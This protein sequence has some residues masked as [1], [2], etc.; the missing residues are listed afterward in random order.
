MQYTS[1]ENN[2]ASASKKNTQMAQVSGISATDKLAILGGTPVRTEPYPQWPVVDRRD[3]EA[4]TTVIQ[5]G[6]WGGA[7]YPGPQT[8]AF[9]KQFTAMQG[10]DFA[11]PMVNGT[12]TMEVALRAVNIGWGDEVIVPAYTFQ[13]TAGA[14]MAAGAIPV[15]VDIDP[16]TYCINPVAIEAAI[17]AKT[18]AIIPVHL[19]AQMADMDAIMAIAKHHN[20]IVIED[21]AHAHGAQWNGQGAGTIGHFG[22]FSFQSSKILTTGEGGVLLCRTQELADRAASI[23]NCGRPPVLEEQTS[24]QGGNNLSQLLYELAKLGNQEQVFTLGTNYRM[25]EIQAALGNVALERFPEQVAQREAM[26]NYLE[27]RLGEV[28]GVRLLKHDPRHSKRSFYRYIFAIEPKVF[29]ANHDQVCLA[30][31]TEGIPCWA[32]Y[33]AMH[34]YDLFQPQ[35]SRLPVPSAFPQYF[36]FKAMSFPEAERASEGEAIWLDESVFRAGQQGI[37]DVITAIA[38]IQSNTAALAVANTVKKLAVKSMQFKPVKALM[39]FYISQSN[40]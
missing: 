24:M 30:L 2:S 32:G 8:L 10:G 36:D 38:K 4:V 31:Y 6:R 16:N 1:V 34:R 15:I 22:S 9:A 13:A 14:P 35:L 26:V 27:K 23:I 33:P 28:P 7:P 25:T 3:V 17:T 12:V 11:V 20:L 37:D 21:C 29:G 5:S 19:G 39:D 18:R 40:K